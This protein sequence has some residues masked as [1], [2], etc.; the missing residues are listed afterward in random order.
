M[1][2]SEKE[3]KNILKFE[4]GKTYF[5]I[6]FSLVCGGKSTFFEAIK[7]ETEKEKEKYNIKLVYSDKIREAFFTNAERKARNDF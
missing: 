6:S 1:E 3:E 7:T 5:F 2:S 4:P